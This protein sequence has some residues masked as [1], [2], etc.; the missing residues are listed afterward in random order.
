MQLPPEHSDTII[1]RRL[2]QLREASALSLEEVAR[3]LKVDTARLQK[4]EAG[5]VR[6]SASELYR[7]TLI[8]NV[9]THLFFEP[10]PTDDD[11]RSQSL[12]QKDVST[13]RAELLA[14][15]SQINSEPDLR[16]LYVLAIQFQR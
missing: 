3:R 1:G 8:F 5:I 13:L 14:L 11:L 10:Q 9:P 4:C 12:I 15:V 16:A 2:R 6:L 7:L